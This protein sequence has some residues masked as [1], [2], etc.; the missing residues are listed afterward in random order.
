MKASGDVKFLNNENNIQ[1]YTENAIYE[2]NNETIK[3]ENNSKAIYQ[4]DKI[5]TAKIFNHDIKNNILKASGDVRAE[6][7][8]KETVLK[9]EKISYFKNENKI[10]TKGKTFYDFQSKYKG[11]TENLVYLLNKNYLSSDYKTKIINQNKDIYYLNKFLF[12]ID[13][14]IVKG[15]DV[16]I[17]SD[18]NLPIEDKIYFTNAIIDLKKKSFIGKDF[19]L[20]VHKGVFNNTENDPRLKGL[21]AKVKDEITII[22][23]GV[24][25]SCKKTDG[26]P[27]WS[28]KADKIIHDKKKKLL[29]YEN[30]VLNFYKIPVFYFPKFFHPDPTVKRQSGFLKPK[31]NDS[32]ILGS[33]FSLPYFKAI[34]DNK[35]A[36]IVPTIFDNDMLMTQVEYR[37]VGKNYNLIADFGNVINYE[38]STEKDKKNFSH[39]FGK[40]DLDLNLKNY[41]S[42]S[43]N[44][45]AERVTNDSYIKLFSPIFLNN[46]LKPDSDILENKIKLNLEHEDYLLESGVETYE[47]LNSNTSDKYQYILPYYNFEWFIKQDYFNGNFNLSSNGANNLKETNQLETSVINNLNYTSNNFY[48]NNGIK[49]IF[50]INFKNVNSVGKNSTKYESSPRTDLISLINTELSLPLIKEYND[51]T[52][53]LTPKISFRV[54]PTNM[55]NYSSSDNKINI[56]NLFSNTRLGLSDTY[57]AGRSMT[58]GLDFKKTKKGLDD[59]NDYFEIKLGTVIRD[60]T[61][62][63]IPTTSTLNQKHSNIF[64]S[65]ESNLSN[66]LRLGYNFSIDNDYSTFEYNDINATI[67]LNNLVTTFNFIEEN[68][69]MGDAN[70]LSNS[71][72]Y[73]FNESNLLTFKT[74]RNRKI[75]LTEYY[76]LVYEYKYDCITAGLKYNKTYYSDS[77]VKPSENLFFTI[78][79]VPLTSYEFKDDSLLVN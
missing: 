27:P 74:R 71:I 76:D 9:A 49:S 42:S 41:L 53:L 20:N 77:D 48:W 65:I 23:K 11:E 50:S 70:I 52:S 43:I 5:I 19:E 56:S 40:Y 1:I 13:D 35:D 17:I 68:N 62:N 18:F 59:I 16:L 31:L 14:E 69:E 12:L 60:K 25:T 55:K 22:N 32:S 38:S 4:D 26:C 39:F 75:N 15:E 10:I 30:A 28:I 8:V 66:N 24:F 33:S 47:T 45:S 78:T 64:G 3:T 79:F 73:K 72:A 44:I 6:N 37:E 46:D 2:K 7:K 58:I 21:S 67:S 29:Q 63:S 61:E 51:Y 54:N 57:E 36:T 34:S